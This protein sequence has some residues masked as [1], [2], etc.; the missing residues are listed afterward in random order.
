M[1]ISLSNKWSGILRPFGSGL[2]AAKRF[3]PLGPI[4]DPGCSWVFAKSCVSWWI[5]MKSASQTSQMR[6]ETQKS[7]W[8]IPMAALQIMQNPMVKDSHGESNQL[9]HKF[10]HLH[11]EMLY[12]VRVQNR[13]LELHVHS[14]LL[15]NTCPINEPIRPSCVCVFGD[16]LIFRPFKS[17]QSKG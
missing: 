17:S 2:S 13:A 14:S 9:S 5:M 16:V 6:W 1:V 12:I 3:F 7:H 10:S 11:Y 8:C 4:W 15:E